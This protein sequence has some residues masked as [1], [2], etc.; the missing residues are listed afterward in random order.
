VVNIYFGPTVVAR[1]GLDLYRYR[2][3]AGTYQSAR[4]LKVSWQANF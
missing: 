3:A 2:D 1:V 4:E